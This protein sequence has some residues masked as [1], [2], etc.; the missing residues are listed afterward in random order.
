[1]VL[2]GCVKFNEPADDKMLLPRLESR[3]D[4]PDRVHRRHALPVSS[5]GGEGRGGGGQ[6]NGLD[7]SGMGY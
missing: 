4:R 1:M 2:I 7:Y 6:L 3:P 5:P